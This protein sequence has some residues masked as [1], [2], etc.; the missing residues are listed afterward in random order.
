MGMTLPQIIVLGIFS[1]VDC[2]VIGVG[3]YIVFQNTL[4]ENINYS[5]PTANNLSFSTI[6]PSLTNT[7]LSTTST[8]TPTITSTS[9]FTNT[10]TP[11]DTPIT[12]GLGVSRDSTEIFYQLLEFTFT[13]E[14]NNEGDEVF[15]GTISDS[16]ATIYLVGPKDNL[17]SVS[18]N[19]FVPKPP[20]ENQSARTVAYL[21]SIIT[22]GAN[23]WK[24][25]TDWLN[26]H[27]I[28]M[29]ES[30]TTFNNREIVLVVT[31]EE[32]QTNVEF[33]IHAI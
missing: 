33:T 21:A 22:I 2:L 23:D 31:S 4:L 10:A 12:T 5:T 14:T 16:L 20:T 32:K 17:L 27:L 24:E 30:R 13:H 28:I 3:V 1:L 7:P 11:S 6:I 19:I 8:F 9:Q 25:G 18:V 15:V 26:E 29:G